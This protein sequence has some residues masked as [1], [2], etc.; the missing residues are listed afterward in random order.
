[1]STPTGE[2]VRARRGPPSRSSRGSRRARP[3]RRR[4]AG[5]RAGC[6]PRRASC[7]TTRSAE[8]STSSMPIFSLSRPM[9][10]RHGSEELL[11]ARARSEVGAMVGLIGHG[12]ILAH[13][14]PGVAPDRVTGCPPRPS[15]PP[16]A[17]SAP[18]P[19]RR[20]LAGL[21]RVLRAARS[22]T[23]RRPP[24]STP[25]RSTASPRCSST[26]CAT[27]SPPTSRSPSTSPAR[28]SG[29]SEYAEYKAKRN[30]TPDEFSSQLP[31]IQEVLDALRIPFLQEG[32]LRGRRH[33]RHA[34]HPGARP[35]GIEVLILH[36]R[37]RLAPAGHRRTPRCS[38]RCA[39]SPSWP[40]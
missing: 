1:M 20:P 28:P 2:P 31:L 34:R 16:P 9:P 18:A 40:G 29:S 21:P 14:P 36:R 15:A 30:K 5:R 17:P 6:C 37:P 38:T 7:A 8:I 25:T 19:A 12:G 22:R 13:R 24:A 23:S 27:S 11:D 4:A 3:R 33:H 10:S 26:C 35:T 32:R 39:A